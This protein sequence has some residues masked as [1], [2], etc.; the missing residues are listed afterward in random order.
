MDDST[1]LD[2]APTQAAP[3]FTPEQRKAFLAALAAAQGQF[4]PIVRNRTARIRMK[5]EKGGGEYTFAYADL[6]E[7]IE[8]TRP[9]LAANGLSWQGRLLPAKEP[10]HVW[11]QSVLAHADGY[12]DVSE[13]CV[14]VAGDIKLFGGQLSYLRRYMVSIQLGIASEDDDD[15]NGTAAGEGTRNVAAAGRPPAPAPR[16]RPQPRA[17]AP[18]PPVG[19]T[20]GPMGDVDSHAG[21]GRDEAPMPAAGATIGAGQVKWL[22]NKLAAVFTTPAERAAFVEQHAP[23]VGGN[24]ERVTEEQFSVLRREL[25]TR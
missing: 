13:I 24:L 4:Q 2:E 11:L 8:K 18:L 12:E 7:I 22:T 23:G 19:D 21:N 25:N 15:E 10:G 17:A 9:A 5:E 14:Q 1:T 3:K 6:A 20:S 16:Q